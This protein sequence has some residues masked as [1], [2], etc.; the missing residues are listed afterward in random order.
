MEQLGR[1]ENLRATA[2]AGRTQTLSQ[3]FAA[4][5]GNHEIAAYAAS[6]A[7]VAFLAG[8]PAHAPHFAAAQRGPLD[9]RFTE[10][11]AAQPGWDGPRATRDHAAFI[12]DL[13]YGYDFTRTVVDWAP[14]QPLTGPQRVEVAADRG[15][16]NTRSTLAAGD[17]CAFKS[18][19]RVE[20]GRLPHAAHPIESEADGIS[21]RWYRG[22]P[23]GRL[24][25]AQWIDDATGFRVLGA[26]AA[27]EFTAA[28]AGPLFVK[29]NESPGELADNRGRLVVELEPR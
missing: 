26:G 10:R 9:A 8:H 13:D 23:L 25:V 20:L 14:G 24:L 19:G 5:V 1:I 21:L 27:G 28:A 29:I 7:A 18:S 22:R 12:A 15:W 17:R 4:P 3:V 11:L 6:W 2:A 16:Q